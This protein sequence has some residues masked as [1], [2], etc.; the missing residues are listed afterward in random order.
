MSEE[1]VLTPPETEDTETYVFFVGVKKGQYFDFKKQSDYLDCE[2]PLLKVD[3]RTF[4][5]SRG[6][7]YRDTRV[8]YEWCFVI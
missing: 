8:N 3:N 1:L 2:A 6:K 7:T 4:V 5:D